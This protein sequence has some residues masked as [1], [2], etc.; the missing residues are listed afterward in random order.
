MPGSRINFVNINYIHHLKRGLQWFGV[1]GEI[2]ALPDPIKY[3]STRPSLGPTYSVEIETEY[4]KALWLKDFANNL[5]NERAGNMRAVGSMQTKYRLDLD[6]NQAQF[7]Y[8]RLFSAEHVLAFRLKN[9][10]CHFMMTQE[11]NQIELLTAKV[12]L[13][14]VYS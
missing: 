11:Q 10:H 5:L 14:F 13:K 6:I 1:D 12:I 7:N 2:I 9:M 4:M 8:H 3:V